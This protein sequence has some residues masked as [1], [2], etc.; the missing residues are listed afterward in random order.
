MYPLTSLFLD[1]VFFWFCSFLLGVCK[2]QSAFRYQESR[3]VDLPRCG[4]LRTMKPAWDK[5]MEDCHSEP[6][7]HWLKSCSFDPPGFTGDQFHYRQLLDRFL[8]FFPGDLRQM[9]ATFLNVG[10]MGTGSAKQLGGGQVGGLV[11]ALVARW[12]ALRLPVFVSCAFSCVSC[13]WM[14]AGPVGGQM[15]QPRVNLEAAR[16]PAEPLAHGEIS[17][18]AGFAH[19]QHFDTCPKSTKLVAICPQSS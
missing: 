1:H 4:Q 8:Q 7:F 16:Y 10:S 11:V 3:D 14:V 13:C 5:L 9:E 18:G 6:T 15:L 17:S 19:P 2:K 12:F